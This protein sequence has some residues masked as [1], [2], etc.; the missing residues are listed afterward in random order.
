[1]DMTISMFDAHMIRLPAVQAQQMMHM[2]QANIYAHPN[3][4]DSSRSKIWN[5]WT[6]TVSKVT[7]YMNAIDKS[8]LNYSLMT[9][10]G[11]PITKGMLKERFSSM[12]RRGLTR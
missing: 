9:W 3:I 10:N 1:M 11:E 12:F 5:V 4:N 7:H 2:A 6:G 8:Q